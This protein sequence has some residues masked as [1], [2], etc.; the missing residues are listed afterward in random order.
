MIDTIAEKPIPLDQI[1]PEVIPGRGGKPVH[2]VTLSLWHR[3]GVRGVKLETLLI[4]GRR[5]TS[6]E[7]LNRFY[8]A[9]SQA[10]SKHPSHQPTPAGGPAEAAPSPRTER[11]RRKAV[12]GAMA[13]LKRRG[14]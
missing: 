9:V 2:P 6:I 8:Q 5:C 4:G 11:D 14:I 12:R 13:D 1:P 10:R 3:R 7:A